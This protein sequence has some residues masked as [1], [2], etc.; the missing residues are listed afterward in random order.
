M[1]H[2]IKPVFDEVGV[3]FEKSKRLALGKARFL[4]ACAVECV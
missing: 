3:S 4:G 1:G 2:F